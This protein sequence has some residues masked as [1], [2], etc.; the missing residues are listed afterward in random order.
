MTLK[1]KILEIVNQSQTPLMREDVADI[2]GIRGRDTKAVYQCLKSMEKEGLI[3]RDKKERYSSIDN[4]S[5]F[6]G[7]V[8]MAEKGFAFIVLQG[9]DD[10]FVSRDDLGGAMDGDTVIVSLKKDQSGRSKQEGYVERIVKRGVTQLVGTMSIMQK[11]E[12]GFV[13]PDNKSANYDIFIKNKNLGDAKDGQKVL[14]SIVKY[15]ENGKNPEGKVL[16][17]LGYPGDKGVDVL[18][19]AHSHGIRMEFPNKVL[20]QAQ[21]MPA[22]IDSEDVKG[23]VDLRDELIFTIDGADAKD[24]DDAISA[25]I[26][27]N[28]NYYLG[29]HIAD[30]AHY[31]REGSPIDKEARIRGTSVYL[32]DRVIPMLPPELSNGICSLHP[33]VDRLTLSV[34]MEINKQG[35]VVESQIVESV[36]NS[37][38]R[39]VYDDVSDYLETKDQESLEK[40]GSDVASVLDIMAELM[41]ILNKKRH[42][43][44]SI[45][46]NFV[47][48]YIEVDENG[49]VVDIYKLERRISNRL[50]E[51]F[52]LITNETVSESYFWAE[53]PF[54]Y[55]I[56]EYPDEEKLNVFLH[57]IRGLGYSVKGV[58]NEIHPRE[59][60]HIIE[61]VAGKKE[62]AVVSRMMLR[63]LKKA[64]YSE[65]NDIHFG[66]SSKYYSHFTAPIRRYP[67]LQI[68]RII[69]ENITGKMNQKQ[70]EHYE[71]ILP[72]VAEHSS[73]TERTAEEAERDV[74]KIKK[75]EY[76]ERFIGERFEGLISGV[77]SFGLFV[78][79][80]NTVEGLVSYN[81]MKDDYYIFDEDR[82]VAIGENFN[83]IYSLGDSVEVEVYHVDKEKSIIDFILVTEDMKHGEE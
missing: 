23:R 16:E 49:K 15:P 42:D 55:R 53:I 39:L 81:S 56:H 59:L 34:L 83:K 8:D 46:F 9:R 43:K 18:S 79:L 60:Q 57:F 50:I 25:R 68:H 48:G 28:G 61:D 71:R 47:E 7:I 70:V 13:I 17:V 44:G 20:N 26:L 63:S 66:L 11:D 30:V 36:I 74:E 24:L 4:D 2:L 58:Q 77:T 52:M 6:E 54:L 69:K 62:E 51:E 45:D 37:K 76:M 32:L 19:I 3:F 27:E 22:E 72:E 67:D 64:K 31:V 41:E 14:V 65:V 40:I 82:L 5:S 29:V 12:Y 1:E 80:E 35:K 10:I 21:E 75:A 78:E 38:A 73:K 33:D